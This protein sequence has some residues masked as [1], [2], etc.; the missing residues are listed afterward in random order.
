MQG[1]HARLSLAARASASAKLLLLTCTFVSFRFSVCAAYHK[2]PAHLRQ[3]ILEA[4]VAD[5]GGL[6][7]QPAGLGGQLDQE[8]RAPLLDLQVCR[9]SDPPQQPYDLHVY[10][11]GPP[12]GAAP[13]SFPLSPIKEPSTLWAAIDSEK[14]SYNLYRYPRGCRKVM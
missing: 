14:G 13:T 4:D 11:G 2:L 5:K 12:I 8:F 9:V 1:V 7:A 6:P 3:V 10:L